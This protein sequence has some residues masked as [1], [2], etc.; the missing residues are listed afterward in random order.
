MNQKFEIAS[1]ILSY[2]RRLEIEYRNGENPLLHD[3]IS[4]A[5]IFVQEAVSCD[6]WNGGTYGHNVILFLNEDDISKISSLEAQKQLATQIQQDIHNITEHIQNEYIETVIIELADDSNSEYKSS[7]KLTNQPIINPDNIGIWK[8]GYIRLFISHR[9]TN[10]K[11]ATN[12]A[13]LLEGYGISSFVAHD[14]IEPLEKWEKEIVKGLKT[15]EIMLVFITDGFFDSCW[16][17]QEIG[18]ALGKGVPIISLKLQKDAPQGFVSDTQA[19][20]GDLDANEETVNKIYQ[21]LTQKLNQEER[22]RK[23]LVNAFANSNSFGET[24]Q[25]FGRLQSLEKITESD[26]QKIIDG[27]AKNNQLYNCGYLKQN[28]RFLSFLKNRTGKNY[29]I[30]DHKQ[31]VINNE[32]DDEDLPF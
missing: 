14:T 21:V 15:M 8:P 7:V 17:N 19:I 11:D 24:I 30:K 26:I 4:N 2:I 10:K 9:D 32:V 6:N 16:T 3:I 29:E 13:T 22:I 23:S 1:K 5:S 25:R 28:S 20:I 12:L 27:F 18:F 31:V